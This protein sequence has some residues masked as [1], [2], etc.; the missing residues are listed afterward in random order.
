MCGVCRGGGG[1]VV[2]VCV[3]VLTG[4]VLRLSPCE[5]NI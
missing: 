5:S 4:T 2:K 3:E 1:A